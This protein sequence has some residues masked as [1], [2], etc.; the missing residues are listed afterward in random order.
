MN[1]QPGPHVDYVGD[2]TNLDQ[3]ADNSISEI[4]ASHIFEHL[5]HVNELP[6]TIKETHRILKP[7]GILRVGVPDFEL[8]CRMFTHPS[9]NIEQRHYIMMVVFGGQVKPY[10]FH[11]AGITMEFLSVYLK[12]AGFSSWKRVEELGI[13]NNDCSTI[14]FGNQLISL[15]VEA[16]K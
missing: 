10:D 15:N 14:R 3:F 7:G 13:F 16:I 4:Y 9:L 2:C 6:A 11:K 8:L 1:I 5:S 12:Q